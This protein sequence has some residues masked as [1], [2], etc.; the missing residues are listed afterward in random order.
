MNDELKNFINENLDL[1]DKN[2][3]ESWEKVYHKLDKEHRGKFTQL[4][5]IAGIDP[6]KVLEYIPI[7]YLRDSKINNYIIPNNATSIESY[8]FKD[9]SSLTSI[10]ISN[11]VTTIGKYAFSDCISLTSVVIGDNVTSIKDFAFAFCDRLTSVTIGNGVT[12]IGD[13]AFAYCKSLMNINYKGTKEEALTKL[14]VKNWRTNSSIE[15]IICT[16]GDILL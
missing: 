12:S 11:N 2:T 3:K 6:A 4:M 8:A 16:D 7:N 1:I 10:E 9:C 13:Y 15:K 5:L 14:K